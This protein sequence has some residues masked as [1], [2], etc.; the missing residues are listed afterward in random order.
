[1]SVD[2]SYANINTENA[3][4]HNLTTAH[5]VE[6]AL[7]NKEGILS[8]QG[9]LVVN[10]G[11]YTGRSPNDKFTVKDEHTENSVWWGKVNKE[12]SSESADKLYYK[13]CQYLGK[14]NLFVQDCYAGANKD[15]RLA[16]RVITEKVWHSIFARNMFIK[17]NAEEKDAFEPGF[18]VVQAPGFKANPVIDDVHSEAAI[19]VD[20]SKKRVFICG[21]DYAGEIKKSIFGVMNYLLPLKG[22]MGMHCSANH[23]EYGESTLFFG[24]SGTGKTTLS[25]NASRRL[26]GDDEHGWCDDG[27]FNFEGGCYAKAI[28]LSQEDEP[29]IYS[30]TQK[31]GT[32]LENV[33][34]DKNTRAL[35]LFDD[36]YT[37]NTRAS[38]DISK[39]PSAD[40]GGIGA[41]PKNIVM[42]TCDAFGVLPPVSRLTAEQAMYHF[43]SGYTAKIAGTERGITEPTA[44]FS[45]CFGAP[46]MARHPNVYAKMLGDKM[47]KHNAKCW[48]VNTGWTEGAYPDGRRMKIKHT[49]QILEAAISGKLD[50]KE[51]EK[52]PI[53]GLQ[54]PR[55][56][57][58][59][60][61]EMLNP[62]NTWQDK[63]AYDKKAEYLVGLFKKNF[64]EFIDYVDERIVR[65]Q[66]G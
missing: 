63:E 17:P 47:Q 1:M 62:R 28:K 66:P 22:I 38:Y 58:N 18:T 54:I 8:N 15:H 2:L 30:T 59:V 25:A 46:F 16:I 11:K 43:I 13:I 52:H 21:T 50:D 45:A 40:L 6:L 29:E 7:K 26:I 36:R 51:F 48:L 44:A 57:Y 41:H 3:V 31:F 53:F 65:A 37:E 39:I 27:I 24:L 19:V 23:D 20:F 49:R 9:A 61:T 12:I 55:L 56:I 33:V 42:L 10:T 35:E 64:E 60:P 14:K 34:I 32:V 5:L 4:F